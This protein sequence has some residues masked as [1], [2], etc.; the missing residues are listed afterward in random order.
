M[1]TATQIVVVGELNA[2]FEPHAATGAALAHSAALLGSKLDVRWV[3]TDQVEPAIGRGEFSNVQ[4]L[5][6]APG[7]PYR[8]LS[9]AL[10]AIRFARE[11]GCPLLGTCAGFQHVIL[12]YARNVLGFADAQHAEY[13][14]NAS[15]LFIA[16]LDCSLV[17][18]SLPISLHADSLAARIYGS[19]NFV[20]QYYCQFGVNPEFVGLFASGPLRVV[21]SDPEG[22]IRVVELANHPFFVATLFLPQ[23]RSSAT[24]PHPLVTGFVS[25]ASSRQLESTNQA[26]R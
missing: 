17:G 13:D 5:W 9:G 2:D 11:Q 19:T 21:G 6:I 4:G 16:R 24:Q 8:S 14:P 15:R 10:A 12:E 20:E 7:S 26:A 1:V 23:L 3:A 25:V 18:R 22:E